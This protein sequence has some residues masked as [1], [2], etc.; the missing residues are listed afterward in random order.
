MLV[1][2]VECYDCSTTIYSRANEDVRSCNCGRVMVMGGQNHFKYDIFG[3][4]HHEVK[5]INIKASA[6]EL[7]EDWQYMND[8]YGLIHDASLGHIESTPQVF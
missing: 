7:Y 6:E 2:A 8:E 3:T 1:N 5:K 4:P